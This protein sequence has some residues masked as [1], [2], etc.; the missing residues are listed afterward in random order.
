MIVRCGILIAIDCESVP[1]SVAWLVM[2]VVALDVC[3][4]LCPLLGPDRL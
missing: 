1:V 3:V 2:C 4:C